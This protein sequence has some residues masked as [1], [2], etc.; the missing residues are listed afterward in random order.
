MSIDDTSAES[1]VGR[2][3]FTSF[4]L[5]AI[6]LILGCKGRSP[7]QTDKTPSSENLEITDVDVRTDG[8][9]LTVQ[10]RTKASIRD[11][12][13]QGVEMPKVWSVVVIPRLAESL[14]RVVL[15]PENR[16]GESV[17]IALESAGTTFDKTT[18][19][20]SAHAPCAIVIPAA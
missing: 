18:G 12:K 5:L 14:S 11:C 20:W 17:G 4:G 6:L 8:S 19:Q 2:G 13:A 10:Y 7:D 1:K 15:V 3:K 16:T 9:T